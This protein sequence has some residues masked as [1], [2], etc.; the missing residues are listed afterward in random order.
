MFH[1]FSKPLSHIRWA[2]GAVRHFGEP[3]KIKIERSKVKHLG[4]CTASLK[5][6]DKHSQLSGSP[7]K[8]N[9]FRVLFMV[10]P[11]SGAVRDHL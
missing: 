2:L 4:L 8:I 3:P 10:D 11:V 9:S 7:T 1:G 6:E 5:R